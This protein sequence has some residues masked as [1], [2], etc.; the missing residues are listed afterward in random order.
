MRSAARGWACSA[1]R[2]RRALALSISWT[3]VQDAA[4][5]AARAL[6]HVGVAQRREGGMPQRGDRPDG[7]PVLWGEPDSGVEVPVA[8]LRK[9]ADVSR[10]E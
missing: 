2:V 6:R 5:G 10:R 9:R 1:A 8:V 3:R 4:Q 7:A